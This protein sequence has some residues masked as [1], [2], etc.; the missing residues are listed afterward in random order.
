LLALRPG[1]S[2]TVARVGGPFRQRLLE[3]GF[4]RGTAVRLVK[5]APL[6]DPLEFVLRGYHVA[7]RREE[8]AAVLIE[9]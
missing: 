4:V 6:S 8:A 7:L 1:R 2:A 3:M 5:A 9:A